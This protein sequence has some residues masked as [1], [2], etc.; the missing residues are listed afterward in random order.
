M[1]YVEE[2]TYLHLQSGSEVTLGLKKSGKQLRIGR[3]VVDLD[4]A[5]QPA[6]EPMVVR[7]AN[8]TVTV[9]SARATV[10]SLGQETLVEVAEG[11]THVVRL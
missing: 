1:A 6:G 8:A 11:S 3:G 4:V 9:K 2:K 10:R 7:G 5:P